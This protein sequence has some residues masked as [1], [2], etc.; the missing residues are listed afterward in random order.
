MQIKWL[1]NACIEI[2]GEKNILID[3]NYLKEPEIDP[4]LI[5]VTH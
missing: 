2:K 1:G 5:L 4:D 3:P